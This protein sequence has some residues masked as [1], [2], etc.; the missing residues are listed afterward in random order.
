LFTLVCV[1]DV[2]E[3]DNLSQKLLS[4]KATE[5]RTYRLVSTDTP[6][7]YAVCNTNEDI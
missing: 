1:Y 5:I 2:H 4:D 7:I 3:A 6:G